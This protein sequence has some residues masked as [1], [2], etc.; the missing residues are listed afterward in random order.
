MSRQILREL[1][2]NKEL[3]EEGF[4]LIPGLL[5]HDKCDLLV[6]Q[7]KR[8]YEKDS[9]VFTMSNWNSDPSLRTSIHE[10]ILKIVNEELMN[11]TCDYLPKLAVYSAKGPG[12]DGKVKLHQDWSMVDEVESRSISFWVALE[13]ID[14]SSGPLQMI[15]RTHLTANF[16]RGINTPYCFEDVATELEK[17]FSEIVLMKKGDALV[18]DHRIIHGSM[19]NVSEKSRFAVVIAMKPVEAKLLHYYK[20]PGCD[21][22]LQL[23]EIAEE[24]FH[25]LP[26]IGNCDKPKHVS[27]LGRLRIRIPQLSLNQIINP[28]VL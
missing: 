28:R 11:K 3:L 26:F 14:A 9:A 22:E 18:F 5:S 13:D 17:K 16:P 23:L 15:R 21:D 20:D 25:L 27:Q 19:P 12:Q 24:E 10:H 2:R 6:T 4:V 8:I 1:E 7:A